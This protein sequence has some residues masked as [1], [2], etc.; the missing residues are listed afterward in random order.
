MEGKVPRIIEN[1]EGEFQNRVNPFSVLTYLQVLARHPRS[2]L[3]LRMESAWSVSQQN[4]K[5]WLI[6]KILSLPRSG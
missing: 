5:L 6:Q 2:L 1:S 3:L 4:A